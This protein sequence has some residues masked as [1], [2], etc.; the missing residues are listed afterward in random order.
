MDSIE[1]YDEKGK[2]FTRV[3]KKET[4]RVHAQTTQG[5]VIGEFHLRPGHRFQDEVLREGLLAVTHAMVYAPSGE[6]LGTDVELVIVNREHLVWVL[7]LDPLDEHLP[8]EPPI[9]P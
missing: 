2:V 9:I 6:L 8:P 5:H 3:V 4:V 1:Y 7:P